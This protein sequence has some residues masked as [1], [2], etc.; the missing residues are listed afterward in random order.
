MADVTD[1]PARLPRQEPDAGR[2]TSPALRWTF[3]FA[4]ALVV[5]TGV[6]LTAF[7]GD[8]DDAF[9]WTVKPPLTAAFLGAAYPD[10]FAFLGLS[11]LERRWA[12]IRLAVV[13]ATVFL[14]MM[15]AATLIHL[16]RFHLDAGSGTGRVAGWGWLLFYVAVWR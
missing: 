13:A 16:D 10:A 11:A 8:T 7:P 9:A 1:S 3:G 12:D 6:Q 14:P 2:P 15:F 5:I 4:A